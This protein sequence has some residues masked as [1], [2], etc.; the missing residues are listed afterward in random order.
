MVC[1]YYLLFGAK[2]G[3]ILAMVIPI[4]LFVYYALRNN[5][6]SVIK[7]IFVLAVII[8][9]G[10]IAYRWVVNNDYLMIRIERAVEGSSSGRDKIYA[11]AWHT[12][13]NSNNIMIYLFG[14]GF[15]GTIHHLDRGMHAHNDWLEIL[16][17]YGLIGVIFYLAVFISLIL[18]IKRMN[19]IE[20]KLVMISSILIWFFK[21]LYS[22]GFTEESF[23]VIM[24]SMGTTLG[25]YKN[26]KSKTY[27][28]L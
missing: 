22:M 14:Y 23:S 8:G 26:E 1:I 13:F 20:M 16:V 10:F 6:H 7:T 5:Q 24:I 27:R 21:T 25:W 4:A 3:N 12:W 15:D 28:C 17:D 9:A 2:R 18:Q 19:K 11:N